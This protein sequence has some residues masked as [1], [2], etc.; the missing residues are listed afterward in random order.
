MPSSSRGSSQ[1]GIKPMS[2]ASLACRQ[3]LYCWVTK[4]AL[5]VPSSSL[6]QVGK[7]LEWEPCWALLTGYK[8]IYFSSCSWNVWVS[9]QDNKSIIKMVKFYWGLTLHLGMFK[10][11][12]FIESFNYK[13][14]QISLFILI[15]YMET[16]TW[17]ALVLCS[18]LHSKKKLVPAAAAAAQSLQSCPTLC[19]TIHGGPPGSSVSGI[20]QA[21]TLEWVAIAFSEK[22]VN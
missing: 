3:I 12:T 1:L 22:L 18:R 10:H 20:L 17:R 4:E 8:Y 11:S 14:N 7:Y 6:I 19:D 16:D 15:L 2:P 21:R 13:N 5:V 9:W